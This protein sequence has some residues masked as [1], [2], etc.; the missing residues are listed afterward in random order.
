M[1]STSWHA[2]APKVSSRVAPIKVYFYLFGP[3]QGYMSGSR[4]TN[5]SSEYIDFLPSN[6]EEGEF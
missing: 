6:L 1:Y 4:V 3:A 2:N 5:A